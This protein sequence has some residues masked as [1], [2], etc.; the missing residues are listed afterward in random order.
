[1]FGVNHHTNSW[2]LR[3]FQPENHLGLRGQSQWFVVLRL[4]PI[5]LMN[6]SPSTARTRGPS[7]F[8]LPDVAARSLLLP[9]GASATQH[10]FWGRKDWGPTDSHSKIFLLTTHPYPAKGCMHFKS[11]YLVVHSW[12]SS[13]NIIYS[14]HPHVVEPFCAS[15]FVHLKNLNWMSWGPH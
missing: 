2:F 6:W 14:L 7:Y 4:N 9:A 11:L 1:M 5:L 13:N 12:L 3:L 10:L 15:F 8:D